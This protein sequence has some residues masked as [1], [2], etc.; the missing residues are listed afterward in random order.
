MMSRA[1]RVGSFV[2]ERIG[3]VESA[4]PEA[5]IVAALVALNALSSVASD[6][7]DGRGLR[8]A[9][10]A[11]AIAPLGAGVAIVGRALTIRYLPARRDVGA[12]EP[13]GRLAHRTAFD[14]AAPGDVLVIAAP[15]SI[16]ASVLGGEALAAARD[17]GIGGVVVD[18]AVRDIDELIELGVP[19]WARR[20]TPMTGRGR[21]EAAEINGPLEIAGVQVVPGD[22]VLADS[23]GISFVPADLFDEVA[24]EILGHT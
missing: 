19:V 6:A 21:I 11:S 20:R 14:L 15:P 9:V 3:R 8:L 7:L 16:D 10:P 4:A 5:S 13:L 22:I 24:R 12:R 1:P 18:G 17:A 23:S 2:P